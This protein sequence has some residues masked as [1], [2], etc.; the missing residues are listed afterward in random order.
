MRCHGG[1]RV[2]LLK[3]ERNGITIVEMIVNSDKISEA[4]IAGAG[5]LALFFL[6]STIP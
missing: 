5:K 2:R 4:Y 3:K 6:K 1:G